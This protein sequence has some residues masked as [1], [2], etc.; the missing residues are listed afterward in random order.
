[1][2]VRK[3]KVSD[4]KAM[5]KLINSYARKHK[6]IPRSLSDLYE[7]VRDLSVF[8]NSRGIV[9]GV[10]GLHVAWEDLAEIRSL[11]VSPRS[12]NKGIGTAL[13]EHAFNEAREL[14]VKKIFVLTYYPDYFARFG[15]RETEKAQLP[16]KIW[17]DCMGCHKFPEC[18]ET[19]MQLK[20]SDI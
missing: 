8:V 1:M 7:K 4:V 11:A 9:Q 18:D 10:C 19:A 2:P 5:Q 15:F 17:S 3:A 20:L 12:Q 16:H 6:I 13:I 14:G